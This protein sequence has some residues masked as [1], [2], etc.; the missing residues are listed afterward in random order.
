MKKQ[1]SLF[2]F[3]IVIGVAVMATTAQAARAPS[4]FFSPEQNHRIDEAVREQ[5]PEQTPRAQHLLPLASILYANAEEWSVWLGDKTWTP[6]T[7]D[8]DIDLLAVAPDHVQ[9]RVKLG[10]GRILD[11]VRLKPHQSLN[12]LTGQIVEGF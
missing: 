1:A 3:L 4:L 5:P 10:N 8:P 7:Q 6:E 11:S 2:V 9:I 12:L